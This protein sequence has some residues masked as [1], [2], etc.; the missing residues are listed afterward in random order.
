MLDAEVGID[1]AEAAMGHGKQLEEV[2]GVA[3]VARQALSEDALNL[4]FKDG[5]EGGRAWREIYDGPKHVFP[6]HE[7]DDPSNMVPDGTVDT[8][9]NATWRTQAHGAHNK[10][11]GFIIGGRL[12]TLDN[13]VGI[14]GGRL[15]SIDSVDSLGRAV[16]ERPVIANTRTAQLA[17]V[18][19]SVGRIDGSL[20]RAAGER[21]VIANWYTAVHP[22]MQSKGIGNALVNH[23]YRRIF[24]NN[25]GSVVMA[26]IEHTGID[27]SRLDEAP[28]TAEVKA[29]VKG[30][31]S[32]TL[33]V[34]NSVKFTDEL[35]DDTNG[36]YTDRQQTRARYAFWTQ[37]RPIMSEAKAAEAS[38]S[39]AESDVKPLIVKRNWEIL[40]P[41]N[42]DPNAETAPSHALI[43]TKDG[44]PI[45]RQDAYQTLRTFYTS[46]DGYDV[47]EDHPAVQRLDADYAQHPELFDQLRVAPDKIN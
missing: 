20:G 31:E 38:A 2:A 11:Q 6:E 40:D 29:M 41:K 28:S 37:G 33:P 45:S 23:T 3:S 47:G 10:L 39:G 17:D 24:E 35:R 7:L 30:G 9:D 8:P 12:G 22:D 21:P 27:M 26:E 34:D 46:E 5:T 18:E 14:I 1:L 13:P 19:D 36:R 42:E 4:T 15:G 44:E 16:G 43:W 25:P 32:A